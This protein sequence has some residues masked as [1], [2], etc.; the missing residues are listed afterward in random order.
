MSLVMSKCM[1]DS[2]PN[3]LTEIT[4]LLTKVTQMEGNVLDTQTLQHTL[5]NRMNRTFSYSNSSEPQNDLK[6][7]VTLRKRNNTKEQKVDGNELSLAFEMLHTRDTADGV[8]EVKPERVEGRIETECS[9]QDTTMDVVC[10][11]HSIPLELPKTVTDDLEMLWSR[12]LSLADKIGVNR[13][14]ILFVKYVD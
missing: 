7:N 9:L 11:E 5:E 10:D 8:L 13:E 3:I 14:K 2:N 12:T 4:E 6:G 1:Q